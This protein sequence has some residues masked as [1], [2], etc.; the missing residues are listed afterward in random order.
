MVS[1]V[2]FG[3]GNVAER[4]HL[5]ALRERGVDVGGVVDV[6][7]ERLAAARDAGLETHSSLEEALEEAEP[8]FV[9]VAVPP[10]FKLEAVERSA[11]AGVDVLIEKPVCMPGEQ[12]RVERACMGVTAFP[13]HNYLHAPHLRRLKELAGD[14]SEVRFEVRR[15]GFCEGTESWLPGWRVNREVSGGGILMDHG[16]HAIYAS[17]FLAGETVSDV[18]LV[19]A[20]T[21]DGVDFQIEFELELGDA[22]AAVS[23]DWTSDERCVRVEADGHRLLDDRIEGDAVFERGLSDGSVHGEWFGGVVDEFLSAR[24]HGGSPML[25]E[26][27]ATM[28]AVEELYQNF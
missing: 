16:Y 13:V 21:C 11:G 22:G 1:C 19:E 7:S 9:D 28:D 15:T 25:H 23:L 17:A 20:E 6:S 24:R 12:G 3:F 2:I 4:G 5:P 8:G 27:V 18:D 26:A 10:A 14:A